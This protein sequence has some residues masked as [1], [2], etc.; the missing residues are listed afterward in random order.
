MVVLTEVIY[1][2]SCCFFFLIN[3]VWCHFQAGLTE[4]RGHPPQTGLVHDPG[5][6]TQQRLYLP[7]PLTPR[8]TSLQEGWK[9][10]QW[11]F[12]SAKSHPVFIFSNGQRHFIRSQQQAP[13]RPQC[14]PQGSAARPAAQ[15]DVLLQPWPHLNYPGSW[16]AEEGPGQARAG[17]SGQSECLGRSGGGQKDWRARG[18]ARCR[19]RDW[20]PGRNAPTQWHAQ[21]RRS[22]YSVLQ[23][24][25]LAVWQGSRCR[26][27]VR[28]REPPCSPRGWG[29]GGRDGDHALTQKP[30]PHPFSTALQGSSD[31]QSGE[32]GPC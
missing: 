11:G 5:H 14:S 28:A 6:N 9:R 24:P 4:V 8:K 10:Q 12:G 15:E 7:W 31:T 32:T 1:S 29:E 22:F 17:Q 3:S 25:R 27:G 21:R 26:E 19:S 23:Q 16:G 18:G 20:W 2:C 13:P 30:A